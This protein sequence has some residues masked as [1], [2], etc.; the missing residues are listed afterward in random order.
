V[1]STTIE[2]SK[3]CILIPTYNNDKTLE[4]V[5]SGVLN[6]A[7]KL[8]VL[9]VDDG[10]TDNTQEILDTYKNQLVV[11]RHPT[12]KGKGIALQTG[13]HYAIQHG[14]HYAI[15]IDSDG[16]HDPADLSSLLTA[17]R[18]DPGVIVMGSRNMGQHDVPTKSSF[19]NKFSN[20][21]FFIETGIHL[22]D[23]QT[24]FRLYPL[25]PMKNMRFFS[26]KFEFEIELIVRLAWKNISFRTVPV[27]V[28]YDF[29]D[30]VSHFRPFKDFLRISIL[31]TCLV[32]IALFYYYP[33]KIFSK[34]I[35]K[36]IEQE[37]I[38]PQESN[39][40]KSISIGFGA[41]IAILPI[42]GFQLLVGFPIAS[43]LRLNKVLFLLA[44]NISIPP[45]IPLILYASFLIGQ[46]VSTHQ[47]D[48]NMLKDW[49]IESVKT[50][51]YQ[52]VI[53]ALLLSCLSFLVFTSLSYLLFRIFRKKRS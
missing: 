52:Y 5:L 15:T 30:R 1:H 22:P 8:D 26:S 44:A 50:N 35:W 29:V 9:V 16:Q 19:G 12:N 37:A 10:S 11:F 7:T 47:V 4:W 49:D 14:Y 53:G 33:K 23:T 46:Y 31:N 18:Q 34:K 40:R 20:F 36:R 21:W 41:F 17:F 2:T 25:E 13:F 42:W 48:P 32:F 6:Q 45:L 27:S 43:M 51:T 39:I 24:G 28:K 3:G 38:K